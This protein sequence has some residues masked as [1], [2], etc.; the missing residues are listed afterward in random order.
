MKNSIKLFASIILFL[1]AYDVYAQSIVKNV[2]ERSAVLKQSRLGGFVDF[3]NHVSIAPSEVFSKY[4][5]DFG[6]GENDRMKIYRTDRD[7]LGFVHYRYK[8]HYKGVPVEG[9]DYILHESYGR[10]SSS[11][12]KLVQ[13]LDMTVMPLISEEG[14]LNIALKYMNGEKSMWE[15]PN[16]EAL[17]KKITKDDKATYFPY[18][19][20][21]IVGPG[22]SPEL[23]EFRLAYKFDIFLSEPY[24]YKTV[25]VDAANGDIIL[26]LNKLYNAN[27]Q[28]TAVT[29][30]SDTVQLTTDHYANGFRLYALIDGVE[31][32]TQDANNTTDRSIIT[33][34]MDYDNFWDN[35]NARLDQTAPDVHFGA[36]NTLRYY[37]EIHGRNSI[38]DD[39][40]ALISYVH[41][42]QNWANASWSGSYMSYG[43][44]YNSPLTDFAICAHELTHGVTQFS[45][46][47]IYSYESGALN[48][49]FSDVF[50]VSAK[51]FA[52]VL[53]DDGSIPW[54]IVSR[55]MADPNKTN[56][57]DTYLGN[58]WITGSN[59]NGGVHT[60]SQVQNYWYYLLVEGGSGTN[61]NG[62]DYEVQGI[63]IKKAEQIAYR[64]L[65]VYL[66]P[67]SGFYEARNG[68]LK[69]AEDLF[70][71]CS[72]EYEQVANAWYAVGV[73]KPISKNDIGVSEI[74][75]PYTSCEYLGEEEDI[76]FNIEYYGA[77][78]T[79]DAGY[80][81]KIFYSINSGDT[82]EVEITIPVALE[83]GDNYEASLPE[84]FD[85]SAPGTYE[86]HIWTGNETDDNVHNNGV[87]KSVISG[88][89]HAEGFDF[90]MEEIISPVSTC[91]LTEEYTP[92]IIR[93]RNYSCVDLEPGV[94]FEVS[95]QI[96][97]KPKVTET[98]ELDEVL[99]SKSEMEY[100]F[101]K[102]ADLTRT[103]IREI[104]V[105]IDYSED[106]NSGNNSLSKQISTGSIDAYDYY[107]DFE[108][109]TAGWKS[110]AIS[111][112]NDWVLGTP[113]KS[114]IFKAAGGEKCW[115]TKLSGP[116]SHLSE[117]VLQ[118]P[119][120]DFTSVS[121][122]V[123]CFD[124]FFR[125]EE[126]YDGM[127]M[128]YST[129]DATWHYIELP[130]YNSNTAETVQIG[131]P[132]FSGTNGGWTNYCAFIPNLAG[133]ESVS[134][135]FRIATD[136]ASTDEGAAIDNFA[137]TILE[138]VDIE[139]TQMI[140][141]VSKCGL[142][143][144]ELVSVELVNWGLDSVLAFDLSYTI[145]GGE[146]VTE[147]VNE[148]L[149]YGKKFVYTFSETAD[150]SE[151]GLDFA[152]DIY[153]T[154][155]DDNVPSNNMITGQTVSAVEMQSLSLSID[156]ENGQLPDGWANSTTGGSN[157]WAV[158]DAETEN[159]R[160]FGS[161]WPIPE[162]G[163][164]AVIND[165][166]I[167]MNRRADNLI[168]PPLDLRAI[169]STRLEFDAFFTGL[170]GA[171]V[172]IEASADGGEN[173]D[174][175]QQ[176]D[177]NDEWHELII[178][179]SAY[180]G[181]SCVMVRFS[182]DDNG[183]Q[184][185]GVCI[186]NILIHEAPAY[187]IALENMYIDPA[188]CHAGDDAVFIKIRNN[189]SSPISNITATYSLTAGP[190][191]PVT[192]TNVISAEIAPSESLIYEFNEKVDIS[193][194]GDYTF[195]A[196]ISH[197]QDSDVSDNSIEGISISNSGVNSAMPLLEDFETFE[198]GTP[199]TYA[200]GWSY[201][202]STE[203][204]AWNVNR[205]GTTT[206][207][208][209]PSR[210]HTGNNG[211]Y[212]Y[213]ESSA[214]NFDKN[215]MLYTPCIDKS[216][217]EIPYLSFWYHMLSSRGT[218][219][220]AMGSLTIDIYD[221][222]WHEA[223]WTVSGNQGSE[224]LQGE[225]D[226][227]PYNDVVKIRFN[228]L[229]GPAQTSDICIDDV[230][231]FDKPDIVDI[232]ITGLMQNGCGME[233]DA[234]ITFT[235]K[236]YG[237]S[238]VN[239][240]LGISYTLNNSD[241]VIELIDVNILPNETYDV[242]FSKQANLKVGNNT[243]DF[244]VNMVGDE[245]H[246]NDTVLSHV[247]RCYNNVI[248]M[249]EEAVCEGEC[250]YL[251]AGWIKGYSALYWEHDASE[252]A[253]FYAD[254]TGLYIVNIEFENGCVL[255][256]SVNIIIYPAPTTGLIDMQLSEPGNIDAGLFE[257][258]LWQDLSTE[259]TF[260]VDNDGQY[261]VTVS[262][263]RG[264]YGTDAF[265]VI[266][267]NGVEENIDNSVMVYPNPTKDFVNIE[268]DNQYGEPLSL[269]LVDIMGNKLQRKDYPGMDR[270]SDKI[271][272]SGL[273]S[274]IYFVKISDSKRIK[275]HKIIVE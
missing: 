90:I 15:S 248:S 76:I 156:F 262:D 98:I 251:N 242:V 134:F 144:R 118:S 224:W 93:F 194:T 123:V 23:K 77:C 205:G 69:A 237:I 30:F 189:G 40:M 62:D 104:T 88:F 225:V 203:L 202:N 52:G 182:Y 235:V 207:D 81:A 89:E 172:Y 275:I 138:G 178:D 204:I 137:I 246:D 149:P 211:N 82:N 94:Q 140:S 74:V 179:L 19:Q 95:Y 53:N 161:W 171:S 252:P 32:H 254:S 4:K 200:N 102:L 106:S 151:P 265:S 43:D 119:C 58:K 272:I 264:C 143:D 115:V 37:K 55:N 54:D 213:V 27:V 147:Q 195:N 133:E 80:K 153:A 105:D 232:G 126:D 158:S 20:L 167:N 263:E 141:P 258:Y 125:F 129:D 121:Q 268:I 75:Y 250:I 84:T 236:N 168:S 114:H 39:G 243:F 145:N 44:G 56:Q 14:A 160:A 6:L 209:G 214:P 70:G 122:A 238:A 216:S 64:N 177:V 217:L 33:D 127:V 68:S 146:P 260:Y 13:G 239:K 72:D 220:D 96:D 230:E 48:E 261:Y 28:G 255:R 18:G 42:G 132:W 91:M 8:Q 49:S 253:S 63:G 111:N 212:M 267:S 136:P 274:G 83:G 130:G 208:T 22:F 92:V 233:E 57:P 184:T 162:H 170:Y 135:R 249:T 38:D 256:D 152:F 31:V 191:G 79:L 47:L 65:T 226:L 148:I 103:G 196:E 241:P 101:E 269:E 86:I 188:S 247:V 180:D 155:A 139:V 221:G 222:E 29:M 240:K 97:D 61:D 190:T 25:Y 120:F 78:E 46:S 100:T 50:G 165:M 113:A 142:G 131:L 26:T 175:L 173:W 116:Y 11:N 17:L 199:G 228:A 219:G 174:R 197:S 259:R 108:D 223:V 59:D 3:S 1:F 87:V 66:T 35:V 41:V 112:E 21:V 192:H 163:K 185:S 193:V 215:A 71:M 257:S 176:L 201:D 109:G 45:A 85:M 245:N 183:S 34:F 164:F 10:L 244:Y 24:D 227:R 150:L 166:S 271:D 5:K 210:D 270:I 186:D 218:L 60:N 7:K 231:I 67:S 51:V 273:A 128:E 169:S 110:Y 229:T 36:E 266:I 16:A 117:M 187:E 73:G 107:Q 2:E 9:A 124:A 12:G 159:G 206:G 154:L 181:M 99:Y 234:D 198:R 157:G